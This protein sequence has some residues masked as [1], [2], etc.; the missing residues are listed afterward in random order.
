M[1]H[2]G[3]PHFLRTIRPIHL[4]PAGYQ[5]NGASANPKLALAIGIAN[6]EKLPYLRGAINGAR[7]FHHWASTVGYQSELLTDDPDPV[8]FQ[9][10]PV[11]MQAIEQK[12]IGMLSAAPKPIF[13]VILYFAGHGLIRDANFS[14][15]LLSDWYSSQKAVAVELLKR[16]LF[17]FGVSQIAIFADACRKF[18]PDMD[19]GDLDAIGVLGMGP[20]KSVF[21]PPVDRFDATQD[22]APAIMIPGRSEADDRCLFTG[23]LMEGLWG[24]PQAISTHFPGKVTSY[25]LGQFLQAE[26]PTRAKAYKRKLYPNFQATLPPDAAYF[27]D[28]QPPPVPPAFTPWPDPGLILGMEP[29]P[30][31]PPPAPAPA[32]SEDSSSGFGGIA[33]FAPVAGFVSTPFTGVDDLMSGL[34]GAFRSGRKSQPPSPPPTP[35][36]P[37]AAPPPPD[38]AQ[39]LAQ[40]IRDQQIPTHFETGSGFA[41]EG[42]QPVALWTSPAQF[43]GIGGRPD[44]WHIGDSNPGWLQKPAPAL[45]ELANGQ[46]LAL[47]ALPHFIAS[48]LCDSKGAQALIYRELYSEI[49]QQDTGQ[50]AI[51][52][53]LHMES[54]S[55]RPAFVADKA[56]ELRQLKHADPTLGVISAYL[57]DSIGDIDN[58]RRMAY[59]YPTVDPGMPQAVPYDIA[60]LAQIEASRTPDGL[61]E[62]HIPAVPPR[63]PRTEAERQNDWTWNATPEATCVVAGFWPWM[64]QGWAFLDEPTDPEWS[65]ILPG[66]PELG[67]TLT[68]ARFAT[69]DHYGGPALAN[70]LGLLRYP[71]N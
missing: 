2:R 46:F 67:S 53:I 41:F 38:P 54:G 4:H 43:A 11:T 20:L 22:G 40:R 48:V 30:P 17:N 65:L 58:I 27:G 19:S 55:L 66:L 69:L 57:Y 24:A 12:L 59:Y 63:E 47:T 45:V 5:V 68:S 9:P 62:V 42:A 3:M 39:N 18:P 33:P 36:P 50:M 52:A 35:P 70:L 6:A 25:S 51:D 16:R 37:A 60:L 49:Y 61:L 21:N 34:L 71:A 7:D 15:W 10:R 8:T 44:W 29:A 14:L 64:R 26:V 28:M 31:P 23:V 13:R 32:P 1:D 56:V